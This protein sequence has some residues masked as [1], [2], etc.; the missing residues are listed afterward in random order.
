L[1]GAVRHE[2]ANVLWRSTVL[3]GRIRPWT[4]LEDAHAITSFPTRRRPWSGRPSLVR[5]GAAQAD[6][7]RQDPD[8]GRLEQDGYQVHHRPVSV[9]VV[10][11]RGE[12]GE[13]GGQGRVGVV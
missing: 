4:P 6:G 13:E 10:A 5:P 11:A 8:V 9:A 12:R 2:L 7:R 1:P 3:Q